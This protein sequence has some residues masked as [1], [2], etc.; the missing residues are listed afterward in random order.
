MRKARLRAE[1]P[2]VGW[3]ENQTRQVGSRLELLAGSSLNEF[4]CVGAEEFFF[5]YFSLFA[6][7]GHTVGIRAQETAR[8]SPASGF[9]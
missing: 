8:H 7:I 1:N 3:W 9:L 2:R 6:G 5:C 4:E